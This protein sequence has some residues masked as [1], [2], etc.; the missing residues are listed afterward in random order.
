MDHQPAS[1]HGISE[2]AAPSVPPSIYPLAAFAGARPPAPQWFTE[3][4]DWSPQRSFVTIEGAA[5]ETLSW[6]DAETPGIMLVHGYSAHAGW[7][8]HIAPLLATDHHVVALSWSGMGRSGWRELYETACTSREIEG[9]MRAHGMLREGRRPLIVAHSMGGAPSIMLA[10]RLGEALAGVMTLDSPLRVK[11]RPRGLDKGRST[12]HAR[13]ANLADALAR[14]RY[15][16]PPRY[17]VPW[18][19]DMFARGG[20]AERQDG[21]RSTY[22]QWRFDPKALDK[23]EIAATAN[24]IHTLRCPAV[25]AMAAQSNVMTARWQA[26]ITQRMRADMPLITIDDCSHQV[27]TDQPLALVAKLRQLIGTLFFLS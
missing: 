26:E 22:W 13:Y 25:I 2:D 1:A 11:A 9:A 17:D 3:A 14:F 7:W 19:A 23:T 6:G 8:R 12:S 10:D 18:I 20:L 4:I 21:N 27:L 16:P 24:L 5:I 15:Q